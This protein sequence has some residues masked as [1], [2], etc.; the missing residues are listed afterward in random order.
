MREI[1]WHILGHKPTTGYNYSDPK[2]LNKGNT[3][4]GKLAQKPPPDTNKLN[5]TV[6]N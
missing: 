5:T 1:T 3:E 4:L 2:S 6:G